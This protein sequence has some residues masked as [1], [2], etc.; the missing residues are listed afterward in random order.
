MHRPFII[1]EDLLIQGFNVRVFARGSSMFPLIRTGDWITISPN[2]NPVV[3]DIIVFKKNDR[4]VCH[5]LV[6]IFMKNGRKYY[7]TRG[8]SFLSSDG[9]I[10]ADQILGKVEK[11]ERGSV[12]PIRR[13]L[14]FIRPA[15]RFGRLNAALISALI[16]ARNILIG[17]KSW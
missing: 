11:I 1:S 5:R 8:D 9:P 12:S 15:L 13:M 7:R 17:K 4:M 10:T 3:D 6:K 2:R 16:M 14:L